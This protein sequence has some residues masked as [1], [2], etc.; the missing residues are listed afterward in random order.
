MKQAEKVQRQFNQQAERFAT[1]EV[2]GNEVNLHQFS[3]FCKLQADD[4]VLE[5]ACGTGHMVNYC[6]PSVASVDGVDIA[7]R[8]IALAQVEAERRQV[9][10]VRFSVG[11]VESLPFAD[12][13]H[14][15]VMSRA[16][17]H[18][19]ADPRKVIDEMLRCCCSGGRLF[20]QDIIG[21]GDP[22]IDAYVEELE[23]AIDNS[24]ARTLQRDEFTELFTE[25]GLGGIHGVEFRIRLDLVNYVGHAV[26]SEEMQTEVEI[27][28]EKGLGDAKLSSVFEQ[29]DGRLFLLRNVLFL[30]GRKDDANRPEE[31]AQRPRILRLKLSEPSNHP[32][33]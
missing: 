33:P 28:I 26:Q 25:V 27:L 29:H 11:P 30:G 21:Y 16:A 2:T 31:G 1:W 4:R 6:A 10:N 12:G 22:E 18:H 32:L 8:M 14:T 5:A 20:I 23:I 7:E 9:G 13:G 3:R 17:F 19:F 24:H 15:V